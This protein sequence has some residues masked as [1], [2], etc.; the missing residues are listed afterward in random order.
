MTAGMRKPNPTSSN[1]TTTR[2]LS[3][4]ELTS[5]GGGN[6]DRNDLFYG[7]SMRVR[8]IIARRTVSR[9]SYL[10]ITR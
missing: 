2:N 10:A 4:A 7:Y 3:T 1:Q 9:P 5:I 8:G 6:Q